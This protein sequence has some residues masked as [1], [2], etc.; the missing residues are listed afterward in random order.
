MLQMTR[1]IFSCEFR[2]FFCVGSMHS[3]VPWDGYHAPRRSNRHLS[4]NSVAFQQYYKM[5][6][7]SRSL[8]GLLA[9]RLV[10]RMQRRFN[11][12]QTDV[13]STIVF[14]SWRLER[15]TATSA[16]Y[17]KGGPLSPHGIHLAHYSLRARCRHPDWFH[18]LIPKRRFLL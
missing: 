9:K 8:G 15:F 1:C 12:I 17:I 3:V 5:M 13:R 4:L 16:V 2:H 6:K 10:F 18:R 7:R 11:F 14:A